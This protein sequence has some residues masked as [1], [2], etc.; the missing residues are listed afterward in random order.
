[1][2]TVR[3]EG[4]NMRTDI[5]IV[6]CGCSGLYAALQLPRNKQILIITK[7]DAESSDSFLAQGGICILKNEADYQ[8]YFKDTMKAGHYEN[9][10]ESVEIMI[11][12]SQDVIRD[13]IKYGTDFHKD[14][15]GKL[16]YT[17]EGAHSHARILFHEDETGKEITKHLLEKVRAL[18]NVTLLEYTTMLDIVEAN[19]TCYGIIMKK[20]DGT[21]ETVSCDYVLLATGGVG[22]VYRHSTNFRHLTGDGIAVAIRHHITLKNINYVQIHPT[23]FYSPNEKDRSFLISESVRGE[24]ALLYDKNMQRFTNELLPR[25]LL[26]EKIREQMKK[27]GTNHVWEDLRPIGHEQLMSH[28]PHIVQHCLE[29][30]YDPEKEPIPVVPAQHYFMGG[31][32][33]N[34]QSKTSMDHLYAIGETACNGVH[35]KNRLASNSLLESLVFAKRA[36]KEIA[37]AYE[38]LHNPM[39]FAHIQEADYTN[40]ASLKQTYR[41]MVQAEVMV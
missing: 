13:L 6:G 3:K 19:N 21:I 15:D 22:G 36:A 20:A 12:S 1:M 40:M 30:G 18:P 7:S 14:K 34:K 5:C 9:D 27:D 4:Q 24:G 16:D 41:H 2:A 17:R 28:F 25:D 33:V 8:S 37:S 26:T 11:R 39:V 38:M 29:M 32:K 35:G 10:P 23:T 31:I